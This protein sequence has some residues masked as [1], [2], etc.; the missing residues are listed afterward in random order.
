MGETYGKACPEVGG[1]PA[2]VGQAVLVEHASV[3]G[4]AMS[5]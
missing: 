4:Q 5:G 2:S 1:L 3:S